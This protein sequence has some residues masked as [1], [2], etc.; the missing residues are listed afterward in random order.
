MSAEAASSGFYDGSTGYRPGKTQVSRKDG[1][2][3]EI[4]EETEALTDTVDA[5]GRREN[6]TQRRKGAKKYKIQKTEPKIGSGDALI[7][8]SFASW[9]LC[10]RFSVFA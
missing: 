5:L 10:V 7:L 4:T 3:Q 9:R 8:S 6:L 2:E 1:F